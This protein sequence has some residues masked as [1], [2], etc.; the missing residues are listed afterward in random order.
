[1]STLDGAHH[2]GAMLSTNTGRREESP[3]TGD[4]TRPEDVGGREGRPSFHVLP[5]RWLRQNRRWLAAIVAAWL[6]IL[7]V[8]LRAAHCEERVSVAR[9]LAVYGLAAGA[10]LASTE[11]ALARPG[12]RE[13][14]PLLQDR[15][16]RIG[17][18]GA[19]ALGLTAADVTLQ[20]KGK[21]RAVRALRVLAVVAQ[22]IVA[23]QNLRRAR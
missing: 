19:L 10:D 6:G 8:E 22:G 11:Y 20:R 18:K 15:G 13:G 3:H 5:K 16:V 23:A 7:A 14:N 1:M 17:A 9:P 2:N 12:L 21:R 4:S